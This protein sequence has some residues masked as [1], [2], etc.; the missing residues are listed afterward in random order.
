MATPLEIFD[1]DQDYVKK[2]QLVMI[3]TQIRKMA[4]GGKDTCCAVK[5]WTKKWI[6]VEN[7]LYRNYTN[8]DSDYIFEQIFE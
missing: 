3:G 7:P 2:Q 8:V 6:T 1:E 5:Q 4:T